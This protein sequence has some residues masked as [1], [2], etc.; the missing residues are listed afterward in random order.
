MSGP[1]DLSG[2]RPCKSFKTSSIVKLMS[3]NSCFTGLFG[4]V[5]NAVASCFVK[6]LLKNSLKAFALSKFVLIVDPSSLRES[7]IAPLPFSLLF[8]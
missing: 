4:T 3:V 8:T 7:G 1:G 2:F 5:G 6:T